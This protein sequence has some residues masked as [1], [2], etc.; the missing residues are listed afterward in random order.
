MEQ[1]VGPDQTTMVVDGVKQP[2]AVIDMDKRQVYCKACG[3]VLMENL[4]SERQAY[5]NASRFVAHD[6][7]CPALRDA[8]DREG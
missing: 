4:S 8:I 7:E 1:R 6:T 2:I 3:K 5:L